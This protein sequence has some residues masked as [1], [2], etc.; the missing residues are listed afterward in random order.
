V[1]AEV[2]AGRAHALRALTLQ[3][4]EL[5]LL[6]LVLASVHLN[7]DPLTGQC[8]LDE[9]HLAVGPARNALPFEVE[10]L[11][12]ERGAAFIHGADYRCAKR[13]SRP[14]AARRIRLRATVSWV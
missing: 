5:A 13:S 3:H 4:A 7:L 11:D 14:R 2:R 9:H 6:P 10:R 12:L 8:T 1:Q